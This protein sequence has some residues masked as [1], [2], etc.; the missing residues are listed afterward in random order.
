MTG[1]KSIWFS[2]IS[3]A[4]YPLLLNHC[5]CKSQLLHQPESWTKMIYEAEPQSPTENKHK[6]H[7]YENYLLLQQGYLPI[8]IHVWIVSY[9]TFQ[10]MNCA[11]LW[12][13]E[14]EFVNSGS[15]YWSRW[16][17]MC[18]PTI[19]YILNGP[20][21]STG[22]KL[23]TY[24]LTFLFSSLHSADKFGYLKS[25]SQFKQKTCSNEE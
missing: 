7:M 12:H 10:I 14:F 5:G 6:I 18:Q 8:K 19:V 22:P 3:L 21:G 11:R 25:A 13:L 9:M 24:W 16:P 23:V 15:H 1:E 2:Y 20:C 4:F 17:C